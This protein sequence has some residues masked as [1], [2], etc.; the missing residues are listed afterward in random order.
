[1]F[2]H[3]PRVSAALPLGPPILMRR[4]HQSRRTS[5]RRLS[6]FSST[7]FERRCYLNEPQGG[8]RPRRDVPVT[9][10]HP[11]IDQICPSVLNCEAMSKLLRSGLE[12]VRDLGSHRRA[13]GSGQTAKKIM[14][15]NVLRDLAALVPSTRASWL[16]VIVAVTFAAF[17][18]SA[19]AFDRLGRKIISALMAAGGVVI[20]WVWIPGLG[21]PVPLR[22]L[23]DA[24]SRA[25]STVKSNPGFG[26][27][28]SSEAPVISPGPSVSRKPLC[29]GFGAFALSGRRLLR[30]RV[31]SS[32]INEVRRVE[33][34]CINIPWATVRPHKKGHKSSS[35]P[36]ATPIEY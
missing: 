15:T 28:S 7:A 11:T 27:R 21:V 3:S 1:M 12:N 22:T 25:T 2:R 31:Q 19:I 14:I 5:Q 17:V 6:V 26:A 16:L 24:S 32:R 23:E 34:G 13:S 4:A 8:D 36:A 33:K 10:K 9:Q 29:G 35:R 30:M 18:L 20:C